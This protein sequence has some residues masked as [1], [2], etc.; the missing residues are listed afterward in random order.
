MKWIALVLL[1]SVLP[2]AAQWVDGFGAHV[3]RTEDG[4]PDLTAPAPR[5]NGRPDL[6]GF[7][8][9]ERT[10]DSEFRSVL[11]PSFATLQVDY[12]TITKHM[13]DIFWGIK[14][15]DEPLRPE[16]VAILKQRRNIDFTTSRCLPGGLPA[17]LFIQ[18]FKIVQAPDEIV[19]ITEDGGP[20][21]QIHMDGRDFP[22]DPLPAWMGYSIGKWDRDTL[23]VDTTG[24][25]ENSWLDAFG[26]PRSETMHIRE[27][28]RR[29]DVGHM[30]LEI[31]IDDPK[32]YTRPHTIQTRLNL[33]PGEIFEYV[34]AENEK[35]RGHT[36]RPQQAANN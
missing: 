1:G 19:M 30:D 9:A 29:I 8:A 6:S 27:R 17:A 10:S 16:A 28:Y 24:F 31:T 3:P 26:H 7:W 20:T 4:R 21:R 22:K 32:Y 5:V 35:D 18:S 15:A 2:V 34:C 11:G 23:A 14:P 12:D 25:N 33:Q 36:G 13:I